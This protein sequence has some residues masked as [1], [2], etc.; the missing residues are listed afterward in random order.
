MLILLKATIK[1]GA[2]ADLFAKP[3]RV[4]GHVRDGHFVGPYIARR[5]VKH[6]TIHSDA[7]DLFS[8]VP[9][10]PVVE[11]TPVVAE[12]PAPVF[13]M[14]RVSPG[15]TQAIIGRINADHAADLSDAELERTLRETVG[16]AS[17]V[18][19]AKHLRDTGVI[20]A[21]DL[22][23]EPE[24]P[25]VAEPPPQVGPSKGLLKQAARLRAAGEKAKAAAEESMNRDRL[26]NTR[27]RAQ[28]AASS[29]RDAQRAELVGQAMI[30]IA[31]AMEAGTAPLLAGVNSKAMVEMLE[32]KLRTAI[33]RA[34]DADGIRGD[35]RDDETL[36]P[37]YVNHLG[38]PRLPAMREPIHDMIRE[39][40]RKGGDKAVMKRLQDTQTGDD[41]NTSPPMTE[42]LVHDALAALDAIGEHHTGWQW[43]DPMG[44]L[45]RYRRAGINNLEQ[46]KAVMAAYVDVRPGS[47]RK[48][49]PIKVAE[50]ALVG[51]KHGIDFFPTPAPLAKRM[52]DLADIKPGDRVL[53]PSAG[54]GDIADQIKLAGASADTL[55]ISDT[56][57]AV[58]EAKGHRMVG[59]DF[60]AYEPSAQ[61][62]AIVMNPPWG[63]NADIRHVMRAW[64]MLKPGGRLVA[65]MSQHSGF[66]SDKPSVA[67]RQWLD[68]V[69]ADV[70][71]HGVDEFKSQWM[72]QGIASRL[73]SV[74][75]P[76]EMRK[77]DGAAPDRRQVAS[78]A[79]DAFAAILRQRSTHDPDPLYK[80]LVQ[81]EMLEDYRVRWGDLL[82][83]DSL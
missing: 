57:R 38:Y 4:E 66:A 30:N 39:L 27:K 16:G 82:C 60:E 50:R 37:G 14:F 83:A 18:A 11:S 80:A 68:E 51:G 77:A 61:Y 70:E 71:A 15:H 78:D 6:E 3:V 48:E 31:D 35:R 34:N 20:T 46:L 64:G 2:A 36:N 19:M 42:D 62:D 52:V 1:G 21:A 17:M 9:P 8:F 75:K 5:Q 40:E 79:M 69:G 25:Y 81:D 59:R 73:V 76:A 56:L 28:Q 74:T 12:P 22:T 33:W 72:P 65:L 23:W 47:V 29:I 63:G 44:E 10:E 58:L 24:P 53:E 41:W 32:S 54:K 67:F 55:E 13:G 7:P 43:R 26:A 45:T 49:D